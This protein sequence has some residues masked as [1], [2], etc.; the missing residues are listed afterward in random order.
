MK[1]FKLPD[2]GE[3]LSEAEI[4]T[5]HVS[6]GDHV[7]EDQPL[8]SVE[9]AKAVVEIPSP[10]SGNV[11]RLCA[12]VGDVVETGAALVEFDGEARIDPGAIVGTL[13]Q[14]SDTPKASLKAPDPRAPLPPKTWIY[15]TPVPATR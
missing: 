11:V 6:P 4:V 3:G 2:L 15:S 9:T 7:V 1:M 14:K 12:E 13:P 8:V 5:W 10:W